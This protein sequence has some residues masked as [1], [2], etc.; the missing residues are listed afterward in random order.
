MDPI[1]NNKAPFK[2]KKIITNNKIS[3]NKKKNKKL[4]KKLDKKI[5]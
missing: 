1:A 3:K 5:K 4:N 2:N